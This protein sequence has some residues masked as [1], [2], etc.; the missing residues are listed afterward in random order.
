MKNGGHAAPPSTKIPGKNDDLH[1][2]VTDRGGQ[3]CPSPEQLV[4]RRDVGEQTRI[5]I[6][7]R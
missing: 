3:D 7:L 5:L 6:F 2:E 1:T 4:R